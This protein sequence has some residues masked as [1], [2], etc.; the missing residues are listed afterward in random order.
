[1]STNA[2]LKISDD[3]VEAL[4]P[5]RFSEPVAYVYNPL[6]YARKAHAE[7]LS[8]YAGGG[9]EI[10][11][12]GMNPGPWGMAQTGVPF[13]TVSLVR[14]WLGIEAPV[15]K[16]PKEHPKRQIE[17]FACPREEVSGARL[18]GWARDRFGSPERFFSRFFVGNYCPLQFLSVTGANLVPEKLRADER[19][20]MQTI[21]DDFLRRW[22]EC[23]GVRRVLG[24]GA[25]A[26]KRA[27]LAL[28]GLDLDIDRILH[29]SPASPAAN[30]G[31]AA[32]VE[33]Q[34]EELAISLP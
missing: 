4:R 29:P 19:Q 17:G 23:L 15:G 27:R 12:L 28:E 14:D 30:R 18:W 24:V 22:V 10:L 7:Y 5:L 13:G 2:L 16:P 31:W 6:D 9:S 21:C 34:L 3:L 1:M 11:L 33:G 32:A 26:E 8:R 20:A 25:F